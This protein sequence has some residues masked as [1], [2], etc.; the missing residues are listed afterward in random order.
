MMAM[1]WIDSLPRGAIMNCG[2][3]KNQ[4]L[5]AWQ[6][7]ALTSTR[8]MCFPQRVFEGCQVLRGHMLNLER[9]PLLLG[10][11]T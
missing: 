4:K 10:E 2:Y 8:K 3:E 9:S 1:T 11:Y 5:F 6:C 7:K